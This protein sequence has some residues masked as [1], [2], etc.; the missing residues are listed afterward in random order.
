MRVSSIPNSSNR[1]KGNRQAQEP[2][3]AG[4]GSA[5]RRL[6]YREV[7]LLLCHHS[8]PQ[9]SGEAMDV[10]A[11]APIPPPQPKVCSILVRPDVATS[12]A[13]VLNS[14]G[15]SVAVCKKESGA[16]CAAPKEAAANATDRG[17]QEVRRRVWRKKL[18]N[19]AR[20]PS[21]QAHGH[22]PR[23]AGVGKR[24]QQELSKHRPESWDA[25]LKKRFQGRCFRCFAR[26]HCAV[27]CRDLL[28]CLRCLRSG[29]HARH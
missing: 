9:Q 25:I 8:S 17:W 28:R 2:D 21:H 1:T 6:S 20:P 16:A 12:Q 26:D 10:S 19:P 4:S 24:L 29:H 22:L 14:T 23:P 7:L 15:D 27:D 18:P 3:A 5:A 13:R 11:E